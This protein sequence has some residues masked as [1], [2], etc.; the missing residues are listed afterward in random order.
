MDRNQR[1]RSILDSLGE[2]LIAILTP[3]SIC[4]F[5]VV[6]LVCILN[7][8]PSSS[9]ASFSSIATAAYSES[10]SDSSWDKFVGALLNS[11]VFVAAITVATFVLVLLF[12]LRCV[13]FLKFYMGFS[14]FIVLGNLGGEILVL[15]IDRFRFPIDSIT[16]L[17]L[18]FNFSVVGVFAVFMSKF[19]ILI[20]QGY[21]VWIGVLVAY[22]FTLLPEWTTW[23]LLVALALYD[24]AA[25][26]L[27]VGPLRLLVEMAISRD[28]DIPALVYEA[29][30]VIRNDSRSVQRRVWREQRSSQNNANRN[31]VR[32]VESAEVEEE[33]VGSSERAEISVPL[34]DRRPEQ[35]ENSET[36]LEGIGLGS[37]GA[38]KLGLG[39]FIFYSV[40]V[41][42]AAMYDL[43][44]VYAC[45][46]AII[47]GL[48]ITLMLLSVYQKALPAL[49]VS[50]MLGVV[51]Y[52]LARL[53]LEVFVV[54]C[55]SNLVMF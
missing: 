12:Y 55:S 26:L 45:Y 16:F 24:I 47:A 13:K 2:E 15:L 7:S 53:L 1:P 37:S 51:F 20:T 41:G 54:Q 18:L 23:V 50:I 52:F 38:I 11:V 34:I 44:T 28:E 10:D 33:H 4:M 30:P 42:R 3:V 31:E 40:L 19:S 43:M 27:P 17:I 5:T 35:A 25:V 9:S 32:V 6:L 22:F 29:R 14:A 48:G 49:P 21:L 8:D 39:D 36:F 46:L